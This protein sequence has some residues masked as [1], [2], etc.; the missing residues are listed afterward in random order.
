MAKKENDRISRMNRIAE[1]LAGKELQLFSRNI[2][3]IQ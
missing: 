2:P 3:F 1:G